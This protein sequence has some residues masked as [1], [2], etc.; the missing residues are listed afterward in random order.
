MAYVRRSKGNQRKKKKLKKGK[1]GKVAFPNKFE[2]QL[3]L[4]RVISNSAERRW[5]PE[6]QRAE[7]RIYF[8]RICG[9]KWHM[10]SA[11]K[12]DSAPT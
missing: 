1:C 12:H 9:N 5:A 11:P 10:T 7:G 3:A 6:Y 4:S 2:A 8:C